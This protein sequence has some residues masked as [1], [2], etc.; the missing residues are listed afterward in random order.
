[1]E[2]NLVDAVEDMASV[3]A[4]VSDWKEAARIA[5]ELLIEAEERPRTTWKPWLEQ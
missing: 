3:T 1:M 4:V 2:V 5:G